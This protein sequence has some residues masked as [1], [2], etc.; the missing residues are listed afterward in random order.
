MDQED[1]SKETWIR[2]NERIYQRWIREK[3]WIREEA[4]KLL[5]GRWISKAIKV[6]MDQ[7]ATKVVKQSK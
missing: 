1:K 7:K 4:M 6:V 3:R 2:S 5:M